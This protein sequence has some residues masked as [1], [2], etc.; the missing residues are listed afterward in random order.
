MSISLL[1]CGGRF[2][3]R[4]EITLGLFILKCGGWT[5]PG[6]PKMAA[7]LNATGRP[8]AFSC[9]WPAYE[10][11]L[12]PKVSHSLHPPG[13]ARPYPGLFAFCAARASVI[14]VAHMLICRRVVKYLRGLTQPRVL[15]E[16]L[17]RW[18]EGHGS[19]VSG[20][21]TAP[22]QALR[23][24]GGTEWAWRARRLVK[25]KQVG[26]SLRKAS[27]APCRGPSACGMLERVESDVQ[28]GGRTLVEG[29]SLP[30]RTQGWAC[31]R[32]AM[33][34]PAEVSIPWAWS[35]LA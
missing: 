2:E 6:Y 13:S 34:T 5:S 15:E 10:G 17:V 33:G 23:I 35:P 27:W 29:V 22:L 19:R 31:G 4:P 16:T 30:E 25:P 8:I 1:M 11:G 12:P 20:A 18:A 14:L 9:S 21:D 32:K 26:P 28:T 3:L 24:L 7:A